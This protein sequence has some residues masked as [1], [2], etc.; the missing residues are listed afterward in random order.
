MRACR[1]FVRCVAR[2]SVGRD[3]SRRVSRSREKS[4]GMNPALHSLAAQPLP[5]VSPGHSSVLKG[6]AGIPAPLPR[7][8]SGLSA[9]PYR[10]ATGFGT[11]SLLTTTELPSTCASAQTNC[12]SFPAMAKP[13]SRLPSVELRPPVVCAK[14]RRIAFASIFIEACV[15]PADSIGSPYTRARAASARRWP[16]VCL[17]IG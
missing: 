8:Q 12:R 13:R 3:S 1:K 17:S 10:T 4:G 2:S 9:Q 7:L 6:D 16:T 14:T 11:W 5:S 15:G